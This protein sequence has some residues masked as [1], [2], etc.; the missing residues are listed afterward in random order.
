MRTWDVRI[1]GAAGTGDTLDTAFI[2]NTLNEA[3]RAGGG[4]VR[5]TPGMYLSGTLFLRSGVTMH[6]EKGAFL[7]GSRNM[8]DYARPPDNCYVFHTSSR[9]VFV[10][11]TRVED[12]AFTGQG[13]IN[14]NLALDGGHRGPLPLLLENCRSI[15]ME[16]I[17]VIDS[18]G[19]SVTFSGCRNVRVINVKIRNSYADGMNPVCCQDVVIDGLLV[20]GSGDDPVCI[21]NDSHRYINETRPDCGFLSEDILIKNTTVR[22]TTHPAFKIGTGTHGLFRNIVIRDCILEDTGAVFCIQLM[23][24]AF[25]ETPYRAI[26]D[27]TLSNISVKKAKGLLDWTSIDVNRPVIRNITLEKVSAEE[28]TAASRIWGLKEAPICGITLR[29]MDLA[30]FGDVQHWLDAA[31]VTG[32]KLENLDIHLSGTEAPAVNFRNSTALEL[33]KVRFFNVKTGPLIRLS[34]VQKAI[35][36]R[37]G[38]P[39]CGI[40]CKVDP[41]VE[42]NGGKTSG[43]VLDKND[44][45]GVDVP[46]TASSDVDAGAFQPLADRCVFRNLRVSKRVKPGGPFDVFVEVENPGDDGAAK[47]EALMLREGSTEREIAGGCWI[48]LKKGR[49]RQVRFSTKWCY[50]PGVYEIFV[51]GNSTVG[52]S[53]TGRV[54][55]AP[56]SFVFDSRL[57][58]IAPAAAFQAAVVSSWV[59]NTGGEEGEKEVAMSAD[60]QPVISETV[61]L[62]PGEKREVT[63]ASKFP[64]S[65][66]RK[67]EL[68]GLVWPWATYANTEA[69]FFLEGD[70]VVVMAGGG[71][72]V[73]WDGGKGQYAVVYGRA[74]GDFTA[75]A[76]LHS[77]TPTGPYAAAGLLVRNDVTRNVTS[78]GY[79]LL[80][81]CPKYGAL[82]YWGADLDGDGTLDQKDSI[83][84]SYPMWFRIEKRGFDF[85]A[86][87]RFRGT[88]WNKGQTFT[89]P[90]ADSVQDVG[91]FGSAYSAKGEISRVVF[92]DFSVKAVR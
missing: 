60:T 38:V 54:E 89:V 63:L 71:R 50:L 9:Y 53:A 6:F 27:I 83:P 74:E 16:D 73:V 32:L 61:R 12:V 78:P 31:H 48:W 77:Q 80:C 17:E 3:G 14:G 15:R 49:V 22:H 2:Q 5:F 33:D 79:V 58:V 40:P 52:N 59:R 47:V 46:F 55:E 70:N 8:S 7:L 68:G 57:R 42:A 37:C 24:P 29:D 87:T 43:I 20:E 56:A 72:E 18:P 90:S 45:T 88:K 25:P 26:E 51:G 19:W 23:R 28:L 81:V 44:V 69:E 65:G 62:S 35:I 92:S 91:I 82:S 64:E 11:G 21:K 67:L 4:V 41:F 13:G 30:H 86:F 84:M 34:D 10:H 39:D 85:T 36:R 66:I 76:Y 1:A 75:R